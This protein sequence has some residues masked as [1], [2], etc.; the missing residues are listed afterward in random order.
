MVVITGLFLTTS[1]CKKNAYEYPAGTP[2]SRTTLSKIE[3]DGDI[4]EAVYNSDGSIQ[5]LTKRMANNT[6]IQNYVFSYENGKL[7]EVNFGSKWKYHYA[8]DQIAYVETYNASGVLKYRSDFTYENGLVTE[9]IQ[10]LMTSAA[11]LPDYKTKYYY[12]PDGNVSRKEIFQYI[13]DEWKKEEEVTIDEYDNYIN[14]SERF[15]SYPYLPSAMFSPNNPVK[16][17]WSDDQGVVGQ[18]VH[19]TYTYDVNARPLTRKTTYRFPG[20]PDTFSDLK[21][22]Y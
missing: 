5:A 18:T 20:F 14:A 15:E 12:R 6:I 16:E 22:E 11:A 4:T 21:I 8:G 10:Y 19:H 3:K 13:N 9:R 17:T 2:A 7:K 1:S